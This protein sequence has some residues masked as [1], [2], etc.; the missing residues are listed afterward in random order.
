MHWLF[1]YVVSLVD[2]ITDLLHPFLAKVGRSS[3]IALSFK[4]GRISS[5]AGVRAYIGSGGNKAVWKAFTIVVHQV[6]IV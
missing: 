5:K 1:T 6:A 3:S 2:V 4:I